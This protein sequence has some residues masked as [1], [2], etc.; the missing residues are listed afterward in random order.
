MT[1]LECNLARNLAKPCQ[2][3][4]QPTEVTDLAVEPD[5]PDHRCCGVG[6][7]TYGR[8]AT[9]AESRSADL[10]LETRGFSCTPPTNHGLRITRFVP[11]DP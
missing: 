1:T 7:A 6:G 5:A 9:V 4:D 11:R 8:Q 2:K 10:G 3:A